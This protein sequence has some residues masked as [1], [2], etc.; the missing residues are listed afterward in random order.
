LGLNLSNSWLKG[1]EEKSRF[2]KI[3][4]DSRTYKRLAFHHPCLFLPTNGKKK[5]CQSQN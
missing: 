1:Q 4:T 3:Q 5:L 2:L